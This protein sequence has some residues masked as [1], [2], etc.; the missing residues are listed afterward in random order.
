MPLNLPAEPRP[1]FDIADGHT[2]R[3]N[4]DG[5][6]GQDAAGR[7]ALAT[8]SQQ[9]RSAIA[10][11]R[12]LGYYQI[13]CEA[14]LALAETELKANPALGRAQLESLEHEAHER[15]LELLSRKAQLLVSAYRVFASLP[16]KTRWP[17]Y[18]LP[19]GRWRYQPS[20]EGIPAT[21]I[22]DTERQV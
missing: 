10:T 18:S 11:A 14:R 9:L 4:R 2:I 20:R 12:K 17:I 15:G 7:L 3:A 16:M 19:L 1:C 21:K 8:A 5:W 13:E 22:Y 6:R